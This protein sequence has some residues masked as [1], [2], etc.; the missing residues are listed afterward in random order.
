[1]FKLFEEGVCWW[2][3]IKIIQENLILSD[4]TRADC[5]LKDKIK[6]GSGKVSHWAINTRV[7]KDHQKISPHL[8]K[9]RVSLGYGEGIKLDPIIWVYLC[10]APSLFQTQILLTVE[11]YDKEFLLSIKW[12]C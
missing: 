9:S 4:F 12:R 7:K 11:R 5:P 3:V 2:S 8:K 10:V 6:I 1:M